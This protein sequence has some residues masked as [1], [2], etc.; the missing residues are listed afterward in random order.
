MSDKPK[1]IIFDLDMT[2]LDSY[3]TIVKR[4]QL[5]GKE[6]GIDVTEEQI[7]DHWGKPTGVFIPSI[8]GHH[9]TIEEYERKLIASAKMNAFEGA[10]PLLNQLKERML[11][12]LGVLTS[13]SRALA[14]NDLLGLGFD[15]D[16]LF[17]FVHGCD[18]TPEVKPHPDVFLPAIAELAAL[19]ITRNEI[20]Y[21]GDSTID[22]LAANRAGLDFDAVTTGF[23]NSKDFENEGVQKDKIFST[24]LEWGK[25]RF[26]IR[27]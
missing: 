12:P 13:A 21:V 14:I 8:L 27:L 7:R 15:P 5:V 22:Y 25:K 26:G 9:A 2:L 23:H 1:S 3:N 17:L 19:G 11:V 18:N 4:Y 16:N 24:L 10:I 6:Y 20:C